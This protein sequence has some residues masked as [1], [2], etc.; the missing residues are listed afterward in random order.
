MLINKKLFSVD[1]EIVYKGANFASFSENLNHN[2]PSLFLNESTQIL[3]NPPSRL[4][5]HEKRPLQ[6]FLSSF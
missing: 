2:T 5:K 1:Q 3:H 6:E 4:S